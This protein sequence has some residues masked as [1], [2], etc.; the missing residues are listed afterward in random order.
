LL[1]PSGIS[2]LQDILK[3]HVVSGEYP[4]CNLRGGT[5]TTLKTLN[6]DTIELKKSKFGRIFVNGVKATLPEIKAENGIIYKINGVLMPP[7]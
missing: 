4:K 7:S 3:Y 5:T 2:T 6:G 1:K